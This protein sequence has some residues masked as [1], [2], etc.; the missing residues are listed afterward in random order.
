MTY[1]IPAGNYLAG[2]YPPPV[3]VVTRVT[4]EIYKWLFG[5]ITFP[6][7]RVAIQC[8]HQGGGLGLVDVGLW[9]LSIFLHLNISQWRKTELLKD[10]PCEQLYA[11]K[12]FS[13]SWVPTKWGQLWW[14]ESKMIQ[15]FTIALQRPP[16]GFMIE[17]AKVIRQYN[18]P[19]NTIKAQTVTGQEGAGALYWRLHRETRTEAYDE[20][21][22]LK[23][24]LSPYL[25]NPILPI[26]TFTDKTI[27]FALRDLRWR[28]YYQIIYIG[29]QK[30]GAGE[31][32][33][34]C[35]RIGCLTPSAEE[36]IQHA[37]VE[38]LV[39]TTDWNNIAKHLRWLY[40]ANQSWETVILGLEPG[41]GY[42]C[43]GEK[44]PKGTPPNVSAVRARKKSVQW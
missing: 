10:P 12:A 18:I 17:A 34:A 24:S 32:E 38:C 28:A 16:P 14:V 1:S 43:P 44:W 25:R 15:R 7:A 42:G 35:P 13:N 8:K 19:S 5:K 33:R 11:W 40:L 21:R 37:T 6:L 26:P 39:V 23:D 2:V 41:E 27:L 9:F 4:R 3:D 30:M 31:K 20:Q 22:R 36:T 29:A